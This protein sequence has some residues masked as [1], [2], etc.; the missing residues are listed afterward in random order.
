MSYSLSVGADA[1]AAL[2]SL[3]PWL[4][5]E[6][7][8]EIEALLVD[9][10][11]LIPRSGSDIVVHDFTRTAHGRVYYVFLTLR[12]DREAAVLNVL[13]LGYFVR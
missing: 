10:A 12:P 3:D 2:A 5:E 1:R 7:L 4:Q 9:A 6:T 11:A 8:D 13:S